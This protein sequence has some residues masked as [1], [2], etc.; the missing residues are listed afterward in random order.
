MFHF[1]Q[2]Q[3][4][5][6]G[7]INEKNFIIKYLLILGLLVSDHSYISKNMI[8]T[9]NSITLKKFSRMA[10]KKQKIRMKKISTYGA[11]ISIPQKE[12]F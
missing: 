8:T 6:K 9:Q 5:F 4:V 11:L 12:L 2:K 3:F 10:L 1:C 7:E